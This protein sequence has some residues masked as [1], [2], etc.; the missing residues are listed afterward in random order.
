MKR[1]P[2]AWSADLRFPSWDTVIWRAVD[3]QAMPAS[4]AT[5]LPRAYVR[6]ARTV[7]RQDALRIATEAARAADGK[8]A[9]LYPRVEPLAVW[10][11]TLTTNERYRRSRAVSS[12]YFSCCARTSP[13]CFWRA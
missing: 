13:V 8:S 12:S 7:P 9:E 6:F 3:F 5:E 10:F 1:G 4:L 2:S 11:L